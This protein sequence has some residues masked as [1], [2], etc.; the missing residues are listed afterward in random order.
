MK[1]SLYEVAKKMVLAWDPDYV[2]F[3][4]DEQKEYNEALEDYK[5]GVNFYDDSEI[6]WD[7]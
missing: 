6:D 5:N 4:P 1:K 2:K 3:L 7:H